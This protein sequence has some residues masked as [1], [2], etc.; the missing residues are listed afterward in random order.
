[1][2]LDDAPTFLPHD[3]IAAHVARFTYRPGWKLSIFADPWEGPVFRV[4][5]KVPDT[6]NPGETTELRINSRMPP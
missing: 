2:R 1:L 3:E 4:V 5:A 6:Y